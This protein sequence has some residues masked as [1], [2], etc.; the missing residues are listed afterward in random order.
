MQPNIYEKQ[1]KI[2]HYLG[3]RYRRITL[4]HLMNVLI[5]VS[6]EQTEEMGALSVRV[7]GL[8]WVIIQYE[9]EIHRL[10]ITDE[11]IKVKTIACENN[12]IYSIR[13]FKLYEQDNL[14]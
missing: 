11:T 14:L 12:R 13:K 7:L 10:L 4:P 5:E 3:D 2:P 9:R 6:G 1:L 8:S